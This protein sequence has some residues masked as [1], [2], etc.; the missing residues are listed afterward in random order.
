MPYHQPE[1]GREFRARLQSSWITPIYPYSH[2]LPF[3]ELKT[4]DLLSVWSTT[5]NK[6]AAHATLPV[7]AV[8]AS[9]GVAVAV[10]QL[11][12]EMLDQKGGR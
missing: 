12:I 1:A 6:G 8:L 2:Q 3:R 11:M 4:S 5:T 9:N 10:A 7:F